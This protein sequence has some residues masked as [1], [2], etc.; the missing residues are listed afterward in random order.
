MRHSMVIDFSRANVQAAGKCL[1]STCFV[2]AREVDD[3]VLSLPHISWMAD[4]H[5]YWMGK[6][7]HCR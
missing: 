6:S 7:F 2:L 3:G 4:V 1:H 5:D